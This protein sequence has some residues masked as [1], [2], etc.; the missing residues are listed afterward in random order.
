[1]YIEFSF[2]VVLSNFRKAWKWKAWKWKAGKHDPKSRLNIYRMYIESSFRVVLSNFRKAWKWKAGKHEIGKLESMTL[3]VDSINIGYILSLVIGLCF[4]TF[5]KL[6]SWKLESTTLKVDSICI[7]CKLSLVLGSYFPPCGKLENW[8]ATP[9][10][11]THLSGL[12]Q[13]AWRQELTRSQAWQKI[14]QGQW[15]ILMQVTL[16][17]SSARTS[18]LDKGSDWNL[19]RFV[20]HTIYI[21]GRT[22]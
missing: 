4:P 3:K 1:M 9:L 17:G 15:N 2:R 19:K 11:W 6:E 7:G 14:D 8:K 13:R 18:Y 20:L 10:N 21:L 12:G 22:N 5:G 16:S